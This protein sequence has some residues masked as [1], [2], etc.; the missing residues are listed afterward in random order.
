MDGLKK[1][2]EDAKGK[3]V[4]K[5]PHALW[6]YH[7]TPRRFIG[8]TP[9]SMTYGSEAVIPTETSFPTLRF[10]QLLSGSNE[11]VLSLDLNLAKERR[12]IAAVRLM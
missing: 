7:T 8:E 5:L 3:W 9:F 11:Q 10:N 4:D 12:E 6:T 2:L 1:I